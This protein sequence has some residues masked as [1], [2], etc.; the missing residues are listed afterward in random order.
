MTTKPGEVYKVDLGIKGKVRLM[1]V[2]SRE[3]LNA[4]RSL[5]ICAPITTS[6][7][8]SK[9]EID[10]GK[11][12]FLREKSY[13]NVQGLQ[14]IQLHELIG[15]IGKLNNEIMEKLKDALKYAME[16]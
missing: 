12:N 8:Y 9:Y 5:A 2:V 13:V 10:I 15:P 1:V 4:P 14:A 3:D 6:Y 11:P 16:L 7:R